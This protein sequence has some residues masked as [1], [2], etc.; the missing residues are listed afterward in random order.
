MSSLDTSEMVETGPLWR[1]G[2]HQ[3]KGRCLHAASTIKRGTR[4]LE[5]A[6][7]L[8][9]VVGR[10]DL[11]DE[12]V[13]YG[14]GNYSGGPA[15]LE[16]LN[17]SSYENRAKFNE[18][19]Y[20][21]TTQGTLNDRGRDRTHGALT[22]EQWQCLSRLQETHSMRAQARGTSLEAVRRCLSSS[23]IFLSSTIR[24]HRTPSG[25][26]ILNAESAQCMP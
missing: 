15:V 23:I 1:H 7:L 25:S 26:G 19:A 18:L 16:A 6:P 21:K 2:D 4:I 22:M 9:L 24:A 8:R 3:I 5:E 11:Y 17:K 13:F 20:E 12:N 14:A 10:V